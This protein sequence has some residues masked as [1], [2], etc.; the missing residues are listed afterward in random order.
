VDRRNAAVIARLLLVEADPATRGLPVIFMTAK[1]QESEIRHRLSLS[2]LGYIVK[3]FDPMT[4][5]V[6]G[7]RLLEP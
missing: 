5:G 1:S 7:R 4:L 3:P 2:A 6:R